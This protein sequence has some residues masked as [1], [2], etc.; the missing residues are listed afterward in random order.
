FEL[1]DLQERSVYLQLFRLS[2]GYGKPTCRISLP[3]LS[4]RAKL[5]RS[6]AQRAVER[7]I[8]KGV[9]IKTGHNIGFGKEQGSEFFVPLPESVIQIF[10]IPS[11]NSLPV[12][13][14]LLRKNRLPSES[15]LP[16]QGTNKDL[17]KK[18]FENLILRTKNEIDYLRPSDD[19]FVAAVMEACKR[20][21]IAFD[22]DLFNRIAAGK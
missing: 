14:R 10:S 21:G 22:R 1:L 15:R 7:L 5:G 11:E 9:V 2:W 12:E 3:R 6:T 13:S 4:E 16:A 18:Q 8:G 19:Q 20:E 17:Y